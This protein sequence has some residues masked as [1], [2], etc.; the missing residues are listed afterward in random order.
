M[1]SDQIVG[2][3]F[4]ESNGIKYRKWIE[5]INGTWN[6]VWIKNGIKRMSGYFDDELT[7]Q[8]EMVYGT[9]SIMDADIYVEEKGENE[10]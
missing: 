3:Y 5:Q 8:D 10:K 4:E 6:L 7:A 2:K 9:G 1:Y